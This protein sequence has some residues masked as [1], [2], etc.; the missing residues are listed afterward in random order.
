MEK[1]EDSGKDP[2]RP[3]KGKGRRETE[4]GRWERGQE[5]GAGSLTA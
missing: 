3:R 4:Q 2:P 5:H 1:E